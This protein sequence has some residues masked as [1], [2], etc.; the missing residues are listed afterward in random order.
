MLG[1]SR[2]CANSKDNFVYGYLITPPD[3]KGNYAKIFKHILVNLNIR[4]LV[5]TEQ[6]HLFQQNRSSLIQLYM[7]LFSALL[8]EKNV[9]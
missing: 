7:T 8:K 2:K 3:Y 1:L 6:Q 4:H 5:L 9:I